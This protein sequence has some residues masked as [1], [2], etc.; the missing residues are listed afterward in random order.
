MKKIF[1]PN[2]YTKDNIIKSLE[3]HFFQDFYV[4]IISKSKENKPD[5]QTYIQWKMIGP[6]FVTMKT[7]FVCILS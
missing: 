3:V 1:T 7:S 6:L 4:I 2:L 5:F